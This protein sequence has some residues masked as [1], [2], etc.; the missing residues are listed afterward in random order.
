MPSGARSPEELE[1]LLEDAFLLH[2]TEATAQLFEAGAVL[3]TGDSPTVAHGARAI[4]RRAT[5]LWTGQH[6][7]LANPRRILL[8]GG[9]GL[10]VASRAI[11]VA[12]RSAD[13]AWRYTISLL[14]PP[15][16]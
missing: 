14:D 15:P 8:A 10:V 3:A 4:A 6:I 12:R 11:N 2:D 13:G 9:T 16:P 1:T 7:Y 5:E